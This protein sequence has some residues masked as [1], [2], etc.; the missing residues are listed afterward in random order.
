MIFKIEQVLRKSNT[1]EPRDLGDQFA[2][3]VSGVVDYAIFMLDPA[4]VIVTWN[5]GAQRIK[6]YTATEVIGRH[7]SIFYPPAEVRNRKPDWE[8]EVAKREGRYEEEGWRLRKD[9]TRFWANVIITA[10]RDETGRLR[11]FGKVTRDL[12]E[13]KRI[14]D[15]RNAEREAEVTRL[16]AHA[17]RMAELERTKADFLN[18]ASHEL[19]G[20]MTV[21]RGYNSMLADGTLSPGQFA[22]VARLLDLKLAQM[23]RLIEQMLETARLER[24]DLELEQEEFDLRFVV[25]EQ[26]D[27][28]R[29]LT[30]DHRLV[31]DAGDPAPLVRGDRTRISTVVANFLDNAIKYSPDGG[32]I[33]C[34]ACLRDSRAIVS[35]RDEG[36][37]IAPEHMPRLFSR[38]GRLPTEEN[39]NIPG[40]GL[41]LFLCKEIANRHGGDI[42]VRSK[43]GVGSEFTLTL[44]PV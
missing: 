36:L 21:I 34:S 13:W 29:P 5:E 28:L 22:S 12:T 27:I 19:R 11:G 9:G 3:L 35:V 2:L 17:D 44:P 30:R 43:P 20:P 6:G 39:M 10:L 24:D 40:T 1:A 26:I 7:F 38:F 42:T 31:L 32:E 4:G 25:Q 41:G 37:G 18:L 8:L 16:H 23:D 14:D 33:R 15:L